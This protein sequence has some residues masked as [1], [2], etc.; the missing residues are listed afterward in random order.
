[1]KK[2]L[3]LMM[4]FL[5]LGLFAQGSLE[6]NLTDENNAPKFNVT[7]A[8]YQNGTLIEGTTT[9]FEGYYFIDNLKEGKY[10][11]A[12]SFAG[13]KSNEQEIAI[14]DKKTFVYNTS[15][16]P[17]VEIGTI[18]ITAP[19][20]N[21]IL[22]KFDPNPKKFDDEFLTE[23][24]QKSIDKVLTLIPATT[25]NKDGEISFGGGRPGSATYYID[26]IRVLGNH[27]IP[28]SAINSLKVH[29]GSIPAK[30]GNTTSAIIEINTKSYFNYFD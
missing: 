21:P 20:K 24:G 22:D 2:M 30:Y 19:R 28:T 9:D 12:I 29:H 27:N 13:V 10:K 4:S 23:T 8:L 18:T 15:L 11:L 14:I 26:G 3:L 7:V 6:G 17:G 25:K 16:E 5:S 1:M